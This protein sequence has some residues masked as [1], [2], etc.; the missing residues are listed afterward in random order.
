MQPNTLHNPPVRQHVELCAEVS[1]GSISDLNLNVNASTTGLRNQRRYCLILHTKERKESE[2]QRCGN[3]VHT[4]ASYTE[5]TE[6]AVLVAVEAFDLKPHRFWSHNLQCFAGGTFFPAHY[7]DLR[8]PSHSHHSSPINPRS[9][10][11]RKLP[12]FLEVLWYEEIA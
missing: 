3:H 10:Q 8:S 5:D 11:S 12:H 1:S 4:N 2:E 6:A 7:T 9:S